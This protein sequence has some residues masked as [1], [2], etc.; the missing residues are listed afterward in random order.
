[1]QHEREGEV[2]SRTVNGNDELKKGKGGE[3]MESKKKCESENVVGR[4]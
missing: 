2:K 1:M 3:K 4:V